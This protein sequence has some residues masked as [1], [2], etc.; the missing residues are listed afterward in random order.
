MGMS[1]TFRRQEGQATIEGVLATVMMLLTLMACIQLLLYV[2]AVEVARGMA[3]AGART[4]ALT[5]NAGLADQEM[6]RE[7]GRALGIVRR[8][9]SQV[10][11]YT[12]CPGG[13]ACAKVAL[14]VPPIV[15]GAGL[16]TGGSAIGPVTIVEEAAYPLGGA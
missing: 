12:G 15:P 10:G 16:L 6:A 8:G 14:T 5:R 11:T 3:F 1:D 2:H 7:F 13:K 4:Y 9:P